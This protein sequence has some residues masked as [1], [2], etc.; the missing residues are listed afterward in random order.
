MLLFTIVLCV[1]AAALTV[2]H[3]V[4]LI[5]SVAAALIKDTKASALIEA[6]RP[7]AAVLVPAHN[8][9]S[10]IVRTV[11][12]IR[13]QMLD[14]DRIVVV[15]HNCTDETERLAQQAGAEVVTKRD[16]TRRGK[17]YA[18]DAGMKYLAEGKAPEVVVMID[19]DCLFGTPDSLSALVRSCSDQNG[20]VQALNVQTRLELSD[21]GARVSEFA[22]R[23]RATL[24]TIGYSRLDLPCQLMGTGMAF[25]WDLIRRYELATGHIAEDA[26]L[27]VRMTLDDHPPRLCPTACVLST[28]PV[29][30]AGRQSQKKR[31]VHGYF[32][33]LQSDLPRLLSRGL[34]RGDINS[35]AMAADLVVP[36]LGLLVPISL[37]TAALSL[38][39]FLTT[40]LYAPLV[41]SAFNVLSLAVFFGLAWI[42]CG[43]DLIGVRELA[44]FPAYAGGIA[45]MLWQY[46]TGSRSSWARANRQKQAP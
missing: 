35:L 20:P 43:R 45:R 19:A 40:D 16:E 44:L 4:L 33:I 10:G 41:L 13:A 31:W 46:L 1:W 9:A 6:A 32:E 25:P 24:R 3:T 23:V 21:A 29:G 8:E 22:W 38:V 42:S 5:Q 34:R 7:Q 28:F 17:G 14:A 39:M 15:A 12:N 36:P 30:D 26:D 2:I 18:L 11:E 37:L 27:G